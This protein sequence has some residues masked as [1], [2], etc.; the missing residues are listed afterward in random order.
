[1]APP[2]ERLARAEQ[3]LFRSWLELDPVLAGDL[4]VH[5]A[6]ERLP[7]GSIDLIDEKLRVLA[8][9][10]KEIR[11]VPAAGLSVPRR[12]DRELALQWIRERRYELERL[13]LWECIPDAPTMIGRSIF[14]LLGRSYAPLKKRI[15]PIL[16]RMEALPRYI[17]QSRSRLRRPIRSLIEDEL[18]TVTRLPAFFHNL[19]EIA[20]LHVPK[21]PFRRLTRVVEHVL[22]AVDAFCNWLVIHVLADC[23]DPAPVDASTFE[24]WLRTRGIPW[25]ARKI[26][27]EAAAEIQRRENRV[28]ELARKVRRKI[29]L[30]EIRRRVQA[31]QCED[32]SKVLQYLRE[33]IGKAREFVAQSGLATVPA[34]DPPYVV[35]APVHI[36]HLLADM[37]YWPAG[38]LEKKAESYLLVSAGDCDSDKMREFCI[39]A[40]Q[41]AAV[42]WGYPGRHLHATLSRPALTPIRML[43]PSPETLDGWANYAVQRMND[44]AFEDSLPSRLYQTDDQIHQALRAILDVRLSS[45]RIAPR[46]AVH[47]LVDEVGRDPVAAAAQVRAM[48]RTPGAW[49]G[50][51]YGTAAIEDLKRRVRAAW[52]SRFD[53]RRFHDALMACGPIPPH[54]LAQEV[55]WRMRESLRREEEQKAR[56]AEAAAAR[57]PAKPPKT[58]KEKK[59]TKSRKRKK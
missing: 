50:A 13:R 36:R 45:G 38:P 9:A 44:L 31:Q 8:R 34:G 3:S 51:L 15:G 43:A 40:L 27:S 28:R 37:E 14:V 25:S 59:E 49:I 52:A 11:A 6:D 42:R 16:A 46:D 41:V 30:Q 17:E 54:L 23:P 10:E 4:G 53:E 22:D 33:K 5:D 35:E 39:P 2:E 58:K 20:R 24:G 29:H 19:K 7:D 32:F 18:E 56:A 48:R 57:R 55:E 12:V 26:E 1:M 47:R 21:T